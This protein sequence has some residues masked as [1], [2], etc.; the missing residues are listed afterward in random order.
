MQ[1]EL[2]EIMDENNQP[3]GFSKLRSQVH[4]DGDWHRVVHIYV[5]NNVGEFLVHLR[6]PNKDLNPG[7]WDT[8]FGGHVKAGSDYDDSAITELFEEIG[9]RVK[10]GFFAGA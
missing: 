8:R 6:S 10:V 5:T 3:L 7:K 9:L 4:K 2:L 1:E